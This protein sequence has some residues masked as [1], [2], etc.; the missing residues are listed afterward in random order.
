MRDHKYYKA[1]FERS[2]ENN[3]LDINEFILFSTPSDTSRVNQHYL[4]L[5][6]I[7]YDIIEFK[8]DT[9]SYYQFAGILE[10]LVENPSAERAVSFSTGFCQIC[11]KPV[12]FYFDGNSQEVRCHCDY[13]PT[14]FSVEIAV[15]SGVIGFANDLREYFP[16][17]DFRDTNFPREIQNTTYDYAKYDLFYPFVGNTSPRA[18]KVDEG[19]IKI[20]NQ[21]QGKKICTDLWWLSICDLDILQKSMLA[22]DPENEEDVKDIVDFT[23]NVKPG[24]YRCTVAADTSHLAPPCTLEWISDDISKKQ[25]FDE[26]KY[27]VLRLEIASLMLD[28]FEPAFSSL[29]PDASFVAFKYELLSG[30]KA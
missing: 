12:L 3:V 5:D 26:V 9:D 21:K 7:I 29:Y 15:P 27:D 14:A 18:N 30:F 16:S 10:S 2:K 19:F 4:F 6:K 1:I 23:F 28:S 13:E 20:A 25:T 24:L 8:K 11:N 22:L 17:T